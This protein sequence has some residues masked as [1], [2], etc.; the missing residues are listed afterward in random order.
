MDRLQ[1]MR[2]FAKVVE[3]GS[4]VR[5]AE[6][7]EISNA[8]ATRFIADLEAHLGTRLLNRSTRRLSLTEAGL[9]YLE[10][11]RLILAEVDDAEA[12][13]S[14]DAKKPTGTLAIYSHAGYGQ[15]QLG[16]LLSGYSLAYPEVVVDVTLSAR[17][18]DL[19]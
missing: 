10:R 15:T 13:V 17:A 11:V 18:V 16:A 4:F 2:V 9:A 19:V 1:S 12:L 6:I 5:A 8:V 14:L 7:L 3:Q